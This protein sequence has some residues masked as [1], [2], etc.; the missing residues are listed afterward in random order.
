MESVLVDNRHVLP[1]YLLF[2]R[3]YLLVYHHDVALHTIQDQ[4]L[5]WICKSGNAGR[6]LCRAHQKPRAER[7]YFKIMRIGWQF[8]I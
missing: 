2:A 4:Y 3:I 1:Y 6:P 8:E 5:C 7:C